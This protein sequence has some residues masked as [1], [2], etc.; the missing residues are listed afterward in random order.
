MREPCRVCGTCVLGGQCRWLF[1]ACGRLRLAVVLSH[2]LG[3]DLHR[4]GRGEFL[5]GKCVFLLERVVQCDVAIGNL[6]EAHATQLQRLHNEKDGLSTLILH[7]YR[8]NNPLEAIRSKT[9]KSKNQQDLG[10]VN[11]NDFRKGQE[12]ENQSAQHGSHQRSRQAPQQQQKRLQN[13][14]QSKNK[15]IE[16]KRLAEPFQKMQPRFQD[17]RLS[18]GPQHQSTRRGSP[19][20]GQ[21]RRCVSLEP[22]CSGLAGERSSSYSGRSLLPRRSREAGFKSGGMLGSGV[23]SRS[24]EYSEIIHKRTTLTS[25]S[26]SLQSLTL[27]HSDH[28]PLTAPPHRQSSSRS[29]PRQGSSSAAL[30]TSS[31]VY[32]FLQLLRSAR[33]RPLPPHTGSRIPVLTQ[34]NGVYTSTQM[35][36]ARRAKM[37][38]A[39]K[40]LEE[41]F[42]D[43]YLPLKQEVS[44]A[45]EGE[46]T[47]LQQ[48]TRQMTEELNSAKSSSQ[49][50]KLKL[51]D[52]DRENKALSGQL[53]EQEGELTAEK[54]NAVKRDK[55]IQGLSLLL[56]EKEKEVEELYG[57]LEDK[58][59]ALAKAR[60]ALHK[61][62]LQKYQGAE[63][64]QAL[65]LSQQAELSRLQTEAHTS[66]LE[67]QRLQRLL[68]SRD[69]E[70]ALL[71]QDKLHL[72]QELELLQQ[73]KKKA[74]KT[75]NDLQ[76]Q[77]K[78]LNGELA[79]R[80]NN[81]EHQ[82]REQQEQTRATEH[83]MQTTIQHLTTS[84]THKE[85]QLQDYM[86]MVRDLEQDRAP[87]GSDAILTKLRERL[88]EKEHALEKALDEKFAAVEEK[89]NEVH[90]LQL[91]VR[92]KE[93]DLER[94]N[95][96][97]THNEETINSFDSLLKEKDVELQ[98]LLNSLKNAQR[99]KQESEENLQRAL[100]EKDSIIQQLQHTLELKTKDMEEMASTVLSRSESQ[101][102][103]LVEQMSQRMKV[104]EVMMSE[105]VKDRERL[106]S[107]N[108]TAVENLLATI[109]S[110]DQL[111]KECAER[112]AQALSDRAAELQNLRRQLTEAQLQLS[113]SQKLNNTAAQDASLETARLLA[114]LAEKDAVINKLLERGQDRDR[115]LAEVKV[116]EAPPPQ[117]LELRQTI[118]VLQE[119]LEEREAELSRRNT[120]ENLEKTLTGSKKSAVILKK[121]LAQKTDA[122]NSALKRENQLKMSL[123]DLQSVVSE[124]ESQVE[125][126][127]ANVESLT[128]TLNTKEEIIAELQQCLAQRGENQNR[129]AAVQDQLF[130]PTDERSFPSLP[131]RE[132]TIIGGDSQQETV[133]SLGDLRLEQAELN[134]ILR[135]EQQLYS[136]LVRAVKEQDSAQRL[137]ALQLE[138]AALTLLRQQLEDGIRSNEELR[139]QLHREIQRA[140][141]REGADPAELESMR[142]A[143]EEAQ[144][145]NV[146]LQARLGQIQS[147]GGGVG[148]ANDSVDTLSLIGEQTSYMSICVGEGLEEELSTEQLRL[149]VLELQ[150]L[151]AELQSR[152]AEALAERGIMGNSVRESEGES[153]LIDL[154]TPSKQPQGLAR[155]LA[156][157]ADANIKEK[158][159]EMDQSPAGSGKTA[160]SPLVQP[161]KGKEDPHA[162]V[163]QCSDGERAELKSL[164]VDCGAESISQLRE[165][166][167][168][169]RFEASELRGLLKEEHSAEPKE[170]AESSGEGDGHTDL[171]QTVQT[172]RSEA[173]NYQKVIHLLKEQLQRN[174]AAAASGGTGFDPELIVSMARE[175]ERLRLEHEASQKHALSL[176]DR[177]KEKDRERNES[178]DN[179]QE[180]EKER[181]RKGR[182][183]QS[184]KLTK[185]QKHQMAKHA[186]YVKSRLPV[187]V[188]PTTKL[189]DRQDMTDHDTEESAECRSGTDS[190][191]SNHQTT[192]SRYRKETELQSTPSSSSEAL[193]TSEARRNKQ[194]ELKDMP[195]PRPE[196]DKV[197][198]VQ[199]SELLTQLE[200]LNQECQEKEELISQLQLQM[201]ALEALRAEIQERD[202][203]ISEYQEALQAAKSTIAYLTACSLDAESGLGQSGLGLGLD[204]ALQRQYAELQRAMQEKD[205][206]NAQLLEC[207][208][209]AESAL[210]SLTTADQP[211]SV[212]G[213]TPSPALVQGEPLDLSD[214][215]E[216]LLSQIKALQEC[217][218][219]L[220]EADNRLNSPDGG[221]TP[222]SD[223]QRQAESL[224]ESL[225]RQCRLN[226]E[227]QEK[228]RSAEETISK[229]EG[230]AS[231]PKHIDG[232][233][234]KT[235]VEICSPQSPQEEDGHAQVQGRLI[236]CL[237]ECILAAEQAVESIADFCTRSDQPYLHSSG[238]STEKELQQ[239][240]DRLRLAFL[241]KDRFE[242]RGVDDINQSTIAGPFQSK[243]GQYTLQMSDIGQQKTSTP[244][245]QGQQ[246]KEGSASLGRQN[247]PETWCT[248]ANSDLHKNLLVLL[249]LLQERAQKVQQLE[250]HLKDDKMHELKELGG[251]KAED[252]SSKEDAQLESLRKILKEKEMCQS[253]EENLK[254]KE[255]ACQKLQENLREKKK[256]C[257]NLE[258]ILKEKDNACLKLEENLREKNKAC[259]NLEEN[260]KEKKKACQ[261]IEENLKEKKKACQNLEENL[262][263]KWKACQELEENLKEKGKAYQALEEKLREKN[264]ACQNLEEKLKEKNKACQNLEEN[265]KEKK[266]AYK[267]LEE[268]L[269]E[270]KKAYKDLE[271]KLKEKGKAYQDLEEKLAAAQALVILQNST[272]SDRQ[273]G[274]HPAP[275]GEQDDKGVQVDEQDLGYETSGRSE[276]EVEREEGT[277]VDGIGPSDPALSPSLKH[278]L[279][280]FSSVENLDTTASSPSYASS[281]DLSSPRP[282][283]SSTDPADPNLDPALLRQQLQQLRLQVESQHKVINHLQRLLRKKSLSVEALSIASEPVSREE[284]EDRR[285]MKAQIAQLTVDLERERSMSRSSQSASPSKIESLVQS[286]A[287]E[288]CELRE[289]IRL[290]RFLGV[291]QRRQLQELRGALGDLLQP[292]DGQPV[293]DTTLRQQLDRSL[294]LLEK[295]EQGDACVDNDERMS[296]ELALRL[297]AELREKDKL[298]R[299]LKDGLHNR[300]VDM[301]Q[302]S[303]SEMSDRISNDGTVSIHDSPTALRTRAFDRASTGT[304][305]TNGGVPEIG[306]A[307]FP[308]GLSPGVGVSDGGDGSAHLLQRENGRLQEQLRSSEELNATLKS[309]LDLTRSILTHSH[310]QSSPSKTHTPAQSQAAERP[311]EQQHRVQQEAG[312]QGISSDLLAEHLLEIRALRQRL[313]ETIRTNERLREQLERKLQEVERDPA[314]TNIF[315]AGSEEPGQLTSE[316]QFLLAQNRTLKE[317]LSQGSRDKQKE[318]ERLR[319][320]LARRTAKLEMSR[321]QCETL[322]QERI[323]LQDEFY[324]L[325]CESKLQKQQLADT[326]QLLQS[327]QVELQ[328]HEQIR[329]STHT[330]LGSAGEQRGGGQESG[331]VDLS[332]LLSEVRRLRLQLERS[333]Q[334]NTALRH[335]LEQQL[336][337]R[338]DHPSTI[339]I[340]YLLSK[341]DDMGKSDMLYTDH[342]SAAHE[343]G[344]S[345]GSGSPA[346]SRLVPGHRLWADRHGR[347]VLGLIEDY[348]AVRKQISEAKRLTTAMDT[349][350]QDSSRGLEC[351]ALSGSVSTMQQVLEEAGRSLKLL[352]RVSLPS[353]DFT[354]MQQDE[355][356]RN[357][358]SRLKSRLAQQ[359][360]MLTGAVKRLR[361]TSQL[362]EGMERIIID[363]LSLTHGV[364]K[365]ARGNL[366]SNYLSVFGLKGLQMEG[367]P[368]ESPV[369]NQPTDFSP[370]RASTPQRRSARSSES[371]EERHSDASSPCSC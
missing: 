64:Q 111:L 356:L 157:T 11:E 65:L 199:E 297:S 209:T 42:R 79:D 3:C 287:R 216:G 204:S 46:L 146:S 118:Q 120:E 281:P 193:W 350:L 68:G 195:D 258:E 45:K 252:V 149:K 49:M 366:E 84:L 5:C 147:R 269:K 203:H 206:L 36:G 67:A 54:R 299:Q 13:Q 219:A 37:E 314:A 51:E 141:Q 307:S 311:Q 238:S 96:L 237:S 100:R 369:T 55:T 155:P 150:A 162:P 200:L 74:D 265:L 333:I 194:Q 122:L 208:N 273:K 211:E 18:S 81:L 53:E 250:N 192:R 114:A 231:T 168:K 34:P 328:V 59:Q 268:N 50:L 32:D 244:I 186:A 277:D 215:L 117:V 283:N 340:N 105:A 179:Q 58:D 368:T 306:A 254:E 85:Q 1:S 226:A 207:L 77:L 295:L 28:T 190:D 107:E 262:K 318:N 93:R 184:V 167:A 260:L 2:V 189:T 22:L 166:V 60:E 341:P 351:Q 23:Q 6:L 337:T 294:S 198:E 247:L 35:G 305:V 174:T 88:R 183:G 354:D 336:L 27:E 38:K 322:R 357:E 12:Q 66:L 87:G 144:R 278:T 17:R 196:T 275:P 41:G 359:E 300:T 47:R 163:K 98:Q 75:I 346:P 253:L 104:T 243:F 345:V 33:V 331:Q 232:A 241:E 128:S 217:K 8:Q 371:I 130:Q 124:L 20:C 303:D 57:N 338:S 152:L 288:L 272:K 39:L 14:S 101:E 80:E 171:R 31:L 56:K 264:K 44:L 7:K 151:N 16:T 158:R 302:D 136:N 102:R 245:S 246:Q 327:V 24:Q 43:E 323:H 143:L 201:H 284:E 261:D 220:K 197:C 267:D 139:E 10:Q 108:Q 248:S 106:V 91:S 309:E 137:Q 218:D 348:N 329:S 103:E 121:E 224:Q 161:L 239:N 112:H 83:K 334:T 182:Q 270:K 256:V 285:M 138:L 293:L 109:N 148:Q 291:E 90:L 4:D 70:L 326:Q 227:L 259:Q 370:R 178:E 240:L 316:L 353:G 308:G 210:A 213:P 185:S 52:M 86:N 335:K 153:D 310:V 274:R 154:S 187:P 92:E 321:K 21:M 233:K 355:M 290:S 304:K 159:N 223:L 140:N 347:H 235:L 132:R 26:V 25:R 173:R 271:E 257:Q 9:E 349:Q 360:R 339:N 228:L 63:E 352:W 160:S 164:L 156:T 317:Q 249:Q 202:R 48:M 286:Q 242:D 172:L 332:E 126:Q 165:Q 94:L 325:Q 115:Y 177:L 324:R 69:A 225:L 40:E 170:S 320:T 72:E 125:G 19:G 234:A 191:Q 176:E 212:P 113:S 301:H 236:V 78:K 282:C 129:P 221:S 319:E 344:S 188:K 71:Q 367:N 169:L 119:R 134:R 30:E 123:A 315:I 180:E 330:H 214:R 76:N 230:K 110:K 99:S 15:R 135:V 266:K 362:K 133:Q 222:E 175:M 313:E 296:V 89:E 292:S 95:N 298:I 62:Q 364:L 289:Q 142:D 365:K 312:S 276:T 255:K 280:G 363:Q 82:Q 131:Q 229:M 145:W 181:K 279:A 342:V 97:L 116:G 343:S 61:A 251:I 205:K 361:S 29:R 358:I 73:Q 127:I 263:E